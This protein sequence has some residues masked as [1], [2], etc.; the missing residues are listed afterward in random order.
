M[1]ALL[2]ISGCWLCGLWIW[3]D[4]LKYRCKRNVNHQWHLKD[5]AHSGRAKMCLSLLLVL[6]QLCTQSLVHVHQKAWDVSD[7]VDEDVRIA[8][9][10]IKSFT[11]SCEMNN[12][13]CFEVIHQTLLAKLKMELKVD[14]IRVIIGGGGLYKW[15]LR[16]HL[17]NMLFVIWQFSY[18]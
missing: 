18:F 10:T 15:R 3:S 12:K 1:F 6:M 14:V 17:T 4:L 5:Q 8:K 2:C 7:P 11:G 16:R 9:M 13:T